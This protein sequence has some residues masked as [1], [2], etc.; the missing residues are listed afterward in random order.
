MRPPWSKRIIAEADVPA[1][2]TQIARVD[3]E[4]QRRWR[5]M[6][7]SEKRTDPTEDAAKVSDLVRA[8]QDRLRRD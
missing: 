1:A 7:E 3:S 2:P 5:R 6:Y 8:M 4:R